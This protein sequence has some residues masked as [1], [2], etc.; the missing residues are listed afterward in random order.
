MEDPEAEDS[1]SVS[2]RTVSSAI[3]LLPI[4]EQKRSLINMKRGMAAVLILMHTGKHLRSAIRSYAATMPINMRAGSI[5]TLERY[6]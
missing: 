3:A 4:I 2:Q 5:L 6:I 1:C